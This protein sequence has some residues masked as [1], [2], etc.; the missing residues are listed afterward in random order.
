M[1]HHGPKTYQPIPQPPTFSPPPPPP[2]TPVHPYPPATPNFPH[3]QPQ[4][5]AP[6]FKP[7]AP[8]PASPM[9]QFN[10]PLAPPASHNAP[11][12]YVPIRA[13]PPPPPAPT[14]SGQRQFNRGTSGSAV[15]TMDNLV[16]PAP[17]CYSCNKTIRGPFV[18]AV[19]KIWCPEHFVCAQPNCGINLEKV[20]F[21][22]ESGKLYCEKDFERYFAPKC[23]KCT[24]PIT[25]ECC[26]ALERAFHP[27]CFACAACKKALNNDNFHL[28]DGAPYCVQ[29]FEK[30]FSTKCAGC[31]FPIEAGDRFVE[32]L[33][34]VWHVDCFTC[35]TCHKTLEGIGFVNRNGKP[36][37]KKHAY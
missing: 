37:C 29:C 3:N 13:P 18:S 20:G 16:G 15:L 5:S 17:N 6:H 23:S 8:A 19:G 14:S 11:A 9:P 28:E 36:Y 22:E 32:A 31:D 24:K 27:T 4:N 25:G 10:R 30:L 1:Q 26:Y 21:V 34:Q 33:K 12:P 35:T 2:A 7:A